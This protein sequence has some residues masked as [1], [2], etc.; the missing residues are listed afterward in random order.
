[1]GGLGLNSGIAAHLVRHGLVIE[2]HSCCQILT[3]SMKAP[4]GHVALGS[5]LI[6]APQ[7]S[8]CC[9]ST[10]F[11]FTLKTFSHRPKCRGMQRRASH[12]MINAE[13]WR[14]EF[15]ARSWKSSP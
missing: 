4:L 9:P 15:R 10:T 14:K 2:N 8:A 13:M 3:V 7:Q 5:L 11:G 6:M 1:M 12:T